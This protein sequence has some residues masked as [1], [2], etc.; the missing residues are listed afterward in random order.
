MPPAQ[1]PSSRMPASKRWNTST[2][3]SAS[4]TRALRPTSPRR[5]DGGLWRPVAIPTLQTPISWIS[6]SNQSF[7]RMDPRG[8]GQHPHDSPDLDLF[9]NFGK[10][11]EIYSSIFHRFPDLDPWGTG[12]IFLGSWSIHE[13]RIGKPDIF[14]R[15]LWGV[16]IPVVVLSD[17]EIVLLVQVFVQ[18][19]WC[20]ANYMCL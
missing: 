2:F 15:I 7:S 19:V 17:G 12:H 5:R 13:F 1:L 8:V 3:Q 16:F 18:N 6:F 20:V 10:D 14:C 4:P 9:M 11:L